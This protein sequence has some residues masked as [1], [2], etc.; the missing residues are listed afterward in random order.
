MAAKTLAAAPDPEPSRLN[1]LVPRAVRFYLSERGSD[2][3]GWKYPSFLPRNTRP[4]S[5]YELALDRGL[6]DELETEAESQGVAA[7]DLLQHAAFYYSAARDEGRLTQRIAE[8]L[9]REKI[10]SV[11]KETG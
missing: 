7:A 9:S 8:E 10:T 3:I 1:L 2:H 4:D 11:E 6:W 5:A